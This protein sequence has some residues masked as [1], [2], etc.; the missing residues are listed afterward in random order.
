MWLAQL[1]CL[2]ALACALALIGTGTVSAQTSESDTAR[3]Q[4]L[5]EDG[6]GRLIFDFSDRLDLPTYKVAADN[7]VLTIEFSRP[8]MMSVPDIPGILPDYVT[9]SRVDPDY[10][11]LRL[12]LKREF[13]INV[14]E[15]GEKL[16]VDI[17]PLDWS[18]IRPGLPSE[19]VKELARR[20]R[21]AAIDAERKRK[22]A[23]VE[24]GEPEVQFSVGRNPTFIRLQ[25]DWNV[26][27]SAGFDFAESK[28][29]LR[30]ALPM[31]IDLFP[32]ISD[33]PPEIKS[34]RDTITPD[35]TEIAMAF[36]EGVKP[37]FYE[38]SQRQ[39]ILDV[40]LESGSPD[41]VNLLSLLPEAA[42]PV[43]APEQEEETVVS[44]PG[45]TDMSPFERP[46][47]PTVTTV[48]STVRVAF[49][50]SNA[51][52]AAVFRRGDVVWMF[53]DT[54][55]PIEQPPDMSA[56]ERIADGFDVVPAEGTQ[57]VRLNLS[58]D[59]LATIA[60]EGQSWVL[61]LGD[62]L[63]AAE[64][65]L[66]F[67]R[68]QDENGAFSIKANLSNPAVVHELRDPEAG[69]VLEVVTAYP[70]SR[71]LLRSLD[72]VDFSALKTV[73]GLVIKPK[74]EDVEVAIAD[75]DSVVISAPRGLIVSALQRSSDGN[76]GEVPG[77]RSGFV[78][79]MPYVEKD[80]SRFAG[81]LE[82]MEQRAS[83]AERNLRD[84][85]R[86]DLARF[87]LANDMGY[88]ALGMVNF[89][90][91]QSTN[92]KLAPEIRLVRAAANVAAGRGEDALADLGS[93]NLANEVDALMWRTIA[94]SQTLDYNGARTDAL[95]AEDS[96]DGYPTWVK[97]AFLMSGIRA[98]LETEDTELA[99]RLLGKV[100]TATLDRDDLTRYELYSGRLDEAQNRFDEALDTY[101]QVIAADVRPTRAEAI[102]QT[103]A[104]LD[105]MQRLDPGRATE[106]LASE[107]MV[108]RGGALEAKMMSLLA[109]LYFRT[110]DYRDAFETVHAVA[111]SHPNSK[112]VEALLDHAR[113]NFANLYLNGQADAMQ[114]VEALSLY[115]DYRE[116]TPP[117]ARGDEMVRNLARRLVKVDLLS[118]AS[119]LLEYQV[120]NRLEGAARAQ[121]AADLA[122]IDIA[123][124]QPQKALEA[125]H[126]SHIA[127][128]PPSLERQRR[129]LEA[130]ALIDSGRPDL[131]LD[132][133][134][135]M[136]GRD[137]DLLRVD[138]QW[139]SERYRE[140]SELIE[141]LYAGL[142]ADDVLTPATRNNLIRAS[143]GF[144][145]AN[146]Q[147]GLSRLR[148]KFG[149]RMS[150]TP[151][152][153]I[154]DF[155]TG[156]VSVTS[157]EFRKVA[158]QVAN[159]DSLDAFLTTYRDVYEPDGSVA[160]EKSA[161]D[162]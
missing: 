50:F 146:D 46:I 112:E 123:D 98:A 121:I 140:A 14:Q 15:A 70:P 139:R 87:Y 104:L 105:K 65:P 130:R 32:L 7:G 8:V 154:F 153:P 69:D 148:S 91:E 107:I 162:G 54:K 141:R 137:A 9:V 27:T 78:D 66:K 18:G 102:Y 94:R 75:E 84:S 57:I 10:R 83:A 111:L 58:T 151:E 92:T 44:D 158:Q 96:I 126:T 142:G 55:T 23:L 108:W 133:L 101:G 81:R 160:P 28:G 144:V 95:A 2:A 113:Q 131:A 13:E 88:E 77:K 103:L 1:L 138:A 59:R 109:T 149:G 89:L 45:T 63:L 124:R 25:F 155:V 115:Y 128:L 34:V 30:F 150:R 129:V 161:Q 62:I 117:G 159:I 12:G 156:Q 36:A 82:E 125:L 99:A 120:N 100:D 51:T 3:L 122:V 47:V 93:N 152:W 67:E 72:F 136:D 85:A 37:R 118:Q 157:V 42:K 29:T 48:G 114:P 41:E 53:F 43:R 11:G 90:E 143:V 134:A 39:F 56:L 73:H 38:N 86:L 71:A 19:V 110:Q 4:I 24:S 76:A 16:F 119:E 52:A 135:S 80:A 147:I 33:L 68:E 6:F 79:L 5:S 61:S 17:L 35:G 132:L 22:A 40:D 31:E 64:A 74:H 127:G 49:P 60:S 106:T 21:D 20:A 116:F 145:L 97:T 26:D